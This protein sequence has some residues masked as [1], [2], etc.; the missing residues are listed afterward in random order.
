ML[1]LDETHFTCTSPPFVNV[2]IEEV[3][4]FRVAA[5]G[6]DFEQY[7][8]FYQ[9]YAHPTLIAGV[10]ESVNPIGSPLN[11]GTSVTISGTGF[12]DSKDGIR[13]RWV[14]QRT[15]VDTGEV[16]VVSSYTSG[17]AKFVSNTRIVVVTGKYHS[18]QNLLTDGV[19]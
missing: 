4:D 12:I 10:D 14:V 18:A 19:S 2:P 17:K 1:F 11:G 3:Y 8:F 7:P 6:V 13:V 5:N 16:T 15:D 9:T